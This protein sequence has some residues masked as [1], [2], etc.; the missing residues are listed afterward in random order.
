MPVIIKEDEPNAGTNKDGTKYRVFPD[1]RNGKT[2]IFRTRDRD[3]AI[4]KA[5]KWA[6]ETNE[7]W[8]VFVGPSPW[9]QIKV[10]PDK[11]E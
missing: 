2:G 6:N 8:E 10:T 7:N 1:R 9:N 3:A 4:R 5:Q 11:E